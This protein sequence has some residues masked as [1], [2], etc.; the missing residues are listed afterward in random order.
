MCIHGQTCNILDLKV[1]VGKFDRKYIVQ[2][3]YDQINAELLM[4]NVM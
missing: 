1:T 4:R 2:Y 3:L